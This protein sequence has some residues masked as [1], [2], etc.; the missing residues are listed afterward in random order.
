MRLIAI[1]SIFMAAAVM[2]L[3]AAA[4]GAYTTMQAARADDCARLCADDSLCVGFTFNGDDCAMW[5]SVPKEAPPYFTTTAR[6]P[7]ARQ[8][9]VVADAVSPAAPSPAPPHPAEREN[10]A[11]ALLGGDNRS[12]DIRPRLGGN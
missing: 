2:P 9:L 10:A 6:A 5:A 11:V 7:G 12:E 1:V 8:Q 4:L 3:H